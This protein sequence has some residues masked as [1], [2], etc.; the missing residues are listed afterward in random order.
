MNEEPVSDTLLRQFLLGQV[1]EQERQ[2]L[3]SMFV[4]GA[5]SNERVMAAEQHL[6]DDYLDDSLTMTERERF[7]AQYGETQTEQ[8][9]LRIAKSIQHWAAAR[10]NVAV[11]GAPAESRWS[12]LRSRLRLK[13]VFMIPIAAVSILAIVFAI[14]VLNSRWQQRDRHL[15]MEQELARLNSPSMLREVSPSM[16]PVR[17]TPGSVRSAEADTE[18]TPSANS[19]F[20]DLHLVWTEKERYQSYQATIRRFDSDEKFAIPPLQLNNGNVILLR[21][22]TRFLSQGLYQ[23]GVR[24]VAADG[25]TG[26]TE[27]YTF[28][29][30][31]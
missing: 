5:L 3:E 7:I 1:D 22:P 12:R 29:V 25:S 2:R 24:G 19:E 9:K 4:T 30:P 15:A 20:V 16:P 6:L 10:S 27:E 8:R 28:V 26:P 17:L 11:V 23:I 31:K 21:L 14:V 13:P 18:V